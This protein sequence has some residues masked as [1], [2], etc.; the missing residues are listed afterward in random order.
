MMLDGLGVRAI[1]DWEDVALGSPMSDLG[2][3]LLTDRLQ[4]YWG[5]HNPPG[6]LKS[7][8]TAATLSARTSLS[9]SKACRTTIQ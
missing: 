6:A 5:R 3:W 1:L 4:A 7:A 9:S 8:R 2:R